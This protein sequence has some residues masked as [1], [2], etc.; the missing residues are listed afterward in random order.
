MDG[1]VTGVRSI[2]TG[3]T[4]GEPEMQVTP[5]GKNVAQ[6]S[7]GVGIAPN[8]MWVKAVMWE[9]LATWAQ[10]YIK[11]AQAVVVEGKTVAHAYSGKKGASLDFRVHVENLWF[12]DSDGTKDLKIWKQSVVDGSVKEGDTPDNIVDSEV[13]EKMEDFVEDFEAGKK[14]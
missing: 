8:N 5:G 10:E 7:I 9:D 4:G 2:V 11:K 14:K 13:K 3:Y 6:V 12:I 1:L